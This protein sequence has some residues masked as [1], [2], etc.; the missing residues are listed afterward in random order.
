[1]RDFVIPKVKNIKPS[2]I[3]KF[4]DIASTIDGVISLGVGEP[5]FDTPWNIASSA[6]TSI[7]EGKTFYTSNAGLKELREAIKAYLV[8]NFKVN[9]DINDMIVTVGGS[10][11]IDL[12]CRATLTEE[13]EVIIPCPAYVSYE[14]CVILAGAK[15]IVYNLEAKDD[16]KIMPDK[17]ESLITNKTKILFMN[18]PNN[19]T[20]AIME[21][22]DLEKIAEIVKKY[23]LLVVTDEI[24]SELTYEKKH[25]S[26]A[27]LP[28]MKERTI[29][30]NGFSKAYSM[31]GWRLGYVCGPNNIIKEMLKIHQF[32]IMC[33]STASQFAGIEALTNSANSVERMRNEYDNRRKYVY[34]RLKK[35]GLNSFLPKGAFYI[36]L[37]ISPFKLSSE[38]FCLDLLNKKKVVVVPGTAFGEN[39]EGY[40][41]ISYAYSIESLK[42][43]LDKIEEY[44]E[45]RSH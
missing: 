20:G 43:A 33:A 35:M 17:L 9:Y 7:E 25:I 29:L 18:Y 14:P 16:F 15:P 22:E 4:F 44:I 10:E 28:G 23:D 45:E 8:E 24:Y 12:V 5:D 40:V 36:F 11:A 19:P 13:D 21:Y 26:I 2:G 42:I 41:R 34:N 32:T 3:R 38:E 1:M 31:T 37:D 27:S 39:G 6:I 30:I